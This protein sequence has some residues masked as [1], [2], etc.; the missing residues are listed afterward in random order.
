MELKTPDLEI[1]SRR[2]QTILRLAIMVGIAASEGLIRAVRFVLAM[3]GM[4]V[5]GR[6]VRVDRP[7]DRVPREPGRRMSG[8]SALNLESALKIEA[9]ATS[10]EEASHADGGG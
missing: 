4:E 6:T 5:Q 10:R 7:E 8:L 1:E 2:G 9:A 3:N